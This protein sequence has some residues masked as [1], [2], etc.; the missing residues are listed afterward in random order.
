MSNWSTQQIN[1]VEVAVNKGIQ[2]YLAARRARVP[3]FVES[4][5]GWRGAFDINKRAA[6]WDMLKTPANILWTPPH[7]LLSQSGKL[8]R[9]VS[10]DKYG[11]GLTQLSSGFTTDIEREVAWR[12]HTDLLELPYQDPKRKGAVTEFQGNALLDAIL[13]QPELAEVFGDSLQIIAEVAQLEQGKAS[14][15]EHLTRYV[16]SRKA[17]AEL[18]SVLISVATGFVANKTLNLG[19]MSLGSGIAS[20]V[21]YQ[22]A[23]SSF[24]FGNTLGALYYSVVPV[25]VGKATLIMTTGGVA[26]ALG[27]IA[28]YTGM[29]TDPLQK[30]LGW[31]DKKLHKLLD[32]LE[33]QLTGQTPEQLEYKDGYVAR[34]LDLAD[35]LIAVSSKLR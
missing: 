29:F 1:A 4:H 21:A 3:Q 32:G 13:L 9:K 5:Y 26:V 23:V 12:I 19:A 33:A 30:S 16:D 27:L 2:D 18:S 11:K 17:A 20:A 25:S 6:G 28:S 14:L 22:S 10:K 24:A 15:T 35:I 8:L 7:F 31:H 34:V